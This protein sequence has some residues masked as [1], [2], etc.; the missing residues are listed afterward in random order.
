MGKILTIDARHNYSALLWHAV[1]LALTIN[2][3]EINTVVPNLLLGAGGNALILGLA[4][5]ILVGGASSMQLL[6]AILLVNR[7]RKKPFLLTGIYLRISSLFLISFLLF[8]SEKNSSPLILPGILAVLTVFSTSGAFANVSYTDI[9]GKAILPQNRKQFITTKQLFASIGS[10]VSALTV[11]AI[12]TRF[13]Y[14]A[15]YALLFLGAGLLLTIASFGFLAI[16]EPVT[17]FKRSSQHPLFNS[18]QLLDLFKNEVNLRWYL[19]LLNTGGIILVIIPFYIMLAV[20]RFSIEDGMVGN[21]L[22]VL[23]LSALITNTIIRLFTRSRT[24]KRI[25]TISIIIAAVTPFTA[26]GITSG[27]MAFSIV[28]VLGGISLSIYQIA[29]SGILL[30]ISLESNRVLYTGLA[31]AGG[32]MYILY[33]II[34]GLLLPRIGFSISF[35]LSA[36]IILSALAAVKNINCN[37]VQNSFQEASS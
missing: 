1:F 26:L 4:S 14:P 33:P 8:T 9:L 29:V 22:L 15:S 28:F 16:R 30:E 13:I 25:L 5:A 10:I 27:A 21:Y 24:Y 31:G 6:F 23:M 20:D 12:L 37:T 18:K 19:L 2:L 7:Q 11:K 3:T 34:N 17:T 32:L 36:L 35:I